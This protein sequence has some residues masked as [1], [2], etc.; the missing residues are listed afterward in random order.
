MDGNIYKQH[1][2][3]LAFVT[4]IAFFVGEHPLAAL[5][6]QAICTVAVIAFAML[7]RWAKL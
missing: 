6:A 7:H 4:S 3:F 2:V 5:A 1:L